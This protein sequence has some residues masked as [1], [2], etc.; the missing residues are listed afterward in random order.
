[1][2]LSTEFPDSNSTLL[3]ESLALSSA[4]NLIDPLVHSIQSPVSTTTPL[5]LSLSEDLEEAATL[6]GTLLSLN[7]D[8]EEADE[9]NTRGTPPETITFPPVEPDDNPALKTM[10]LPM[11][12]FPPTNELVPPSRP[13]PALNMM[14]PPKPSSDKPIPP[15]MD[16][17][18]AFPNKAP[19][20]TT[21]IFPPLP[22]TAGIIALISPLFKREIPVETINSPLEFKIFW[23][24]TIS[25]IPLEAPTEMEPP[26]FP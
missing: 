9:L 1:V 19:P 26:E 24:D 11:K 7:K 13:F 18:E 16:T 20:L 21:S 3:V 10:S 14:D 6:K 5:L 22:S 8:R 23:E 4:E 2:E 15:I 25:T 12:P 17:V